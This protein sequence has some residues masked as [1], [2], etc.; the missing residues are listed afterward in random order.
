MAAFLSYFRLQE[1]RRLQQAI[2]EDPLSLV[3]MLINERAGLSP[4][5][6]GALRQRLQG[7][8]AGPNQNLDVLY[9]GRNGQ[10]GEIPLSTRA[11]WEENGMNPAAEAELNKTFKRFGKGSSN[12]S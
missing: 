3:N 8:G 1:E 11:K 10:P 7:M 6:E 2:K 5:L 12:R 4:Q 9:A